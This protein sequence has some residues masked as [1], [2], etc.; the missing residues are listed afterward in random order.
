MSHKPGGML[1]LLSARPAV[2]PAT[3][4]RA[5]TSLV[6]DS[7]HLQADCQEPGSAPEPYAPQSSMGC[8]YVFS[9]LV[10][11]LDGDWPGRALLQTD[12]VMHKR[13][14]ALVKPRV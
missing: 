7:C 11:E 13:R 1:P 9:L 6:Y 14:G 5:A 3:L 8:L 4:K 10:G 12:S 2:T